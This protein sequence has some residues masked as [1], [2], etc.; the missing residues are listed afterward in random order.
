M[1]IIGASVAVVI[2]VFLPSRNAVPGISDSN[3]FTEL[4]LAAM[5]AMFDLSAALTVGWLVAA[6]ALAPPQPSGIFDVGGYRAMRAASLSAWVWTAVS[7]AMIPLTVADVAGTSLGRAVNANAVINGLA[8]SNIRGYLICAI[9]AVFIALLSRIILRPGWAA[10]L[11]LAAIIGLLPQALSGHA[12][13]AD[14]HDV[15]VDTMIFHLVGISLWIGGLLAFL[16][17]VRQNVG[18][19][20]V[21]ARRYSNL[22]LVAFIAVAI[23]GIVNAWIRLTYFSDLWT[24]GYGRLVVIK[25]I[26]LI[27]LGFFGY[28]QRKRALPAIALGKR[29]PLVR[30]ASMELL[31][32]GAT[33]GVAA[34]LGRTAPPPPSGVLPIG[35]NLNIEATLGFPL[36]GP[37]TIS[38]LLFDW[39]FDYLMGTAVIVAAGLYFYGV[40]RMHRRG[41]AWPPGRT[42]AWMLGC[43]TVLLA[44]S[45]GLGRYAQTQFSIHMIAH[46]MLGMIAPIMLVLGAPITLALRT[47]P[48]AGRNNP[49]GLREAIVSVVHG[50]VAKFVTHPLIVF[51]LFV[52]SF[53]AIYFTSLFD[54]VIDSHFG[55]LLM[56]V[57][58][59]VVG[60][61]YYW[62]IIGI[63]PGPRR[64][65]PMV[66][67]AMLLAALPFHAFFGLALM[68]SNTLLGSSY[69]HGL[70]LPWVGDLIGDQRLGGS[71]AW[72]ATELP[73]IIVMIALLAQWAKAD[74]RENRRT[75]RRKDTHGDEEL[76]AYNNMLAGMAA[77]SARAGRTTTTQ[78]TESPPAS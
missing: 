26:A 72:G 57:H 41:D 21:V 78:S 23:S 66:K 61:L 40:H 44:T 50:R 45:S 8:F 22:A 65:Q 30:L 75:D 43:L 73:I 7:L 49:P 56:G 9:I 33:V 36:A 6:V 5:K 68:N 53:Y 52:G 11:L 46:M 37:P 74:D 25:A 70:A 38:R 54:V 77:Q 1:V 32:M 18:N 76:E 39:R 63:D 12:S 31:I 3:Q 60:Y 47:L 13:G 55:H 58:F 16:G 15:A 17:M 20:P 24:T 69:Y 34:A 71:I 48:A 27:T 14:D 28:A 29:R 4:M 10:V 64:V 19:L 59:L 2:S 67:L 51:P 35:L 42:W 62:V